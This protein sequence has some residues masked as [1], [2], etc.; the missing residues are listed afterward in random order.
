MVGMRITVALIAAGIV[1][2]LMHNVVAGLVALAVVWAIMP[3]P[4]AGHRVMIEDL[5]TG[6]IEIQDNDSQ[7]QRYINDR[8]RKDK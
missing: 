6:K 1:A 7:T 2:G 8:M 4:A 3:R 5:R